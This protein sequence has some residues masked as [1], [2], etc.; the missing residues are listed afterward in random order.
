VLV[1]S[2]VP[3]AQ[4]AE[5]FVTAGSNYP[6]YG[7][8][9]AAKTNGV[10]GKVVFCKFGETAA[11][12]P[13]AVFGNIALIERGGNVFSQKA[14]NAK[15]A[16]A[17]AVIIFNN[18]PGGFAGT[19]GGAGSW[20]PVVSVSDTTGAAL[21]NWNSNATVVNKISDWDSWDGTSMATPH[22]SGVAALV[23]GAA[24]TALTPGQIEYILYSTAKDLGTPG[25]DT[26]YGW[27]IPDAA[28]ATSLAKLF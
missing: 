17:T 23:A 2:S 13:A 16:G 12:F 14:I 7:F 18:A 6:A 11:D 8:L 27:G 25:Y 9:H 28:K 5:A 10:T 21:K 15:A 26:T 20:L 22:V 4:G 24:R 1:L 3:K 19:L